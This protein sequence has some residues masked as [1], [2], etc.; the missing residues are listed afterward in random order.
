MNPIYL[1]NAAT[2][3]LSP[4]VIKAMT[5]A[6]QESFGNPSSTHQLGRKAKALVE[7]VRKDLAKQFKVSAGEIFFT[8]GGT[9]ADNTVLR[10]AVSNLNITRFI[11]SKIEHHAVLHTLDALKE[12]YQ[13]QI[14][15]VDLDANGAVDLK[16][17][18]KLLKDKAP[19]TLVSLMHVNNEIGNLLDMQAV[20][21]LC[22]EHQALFHSDT[23]QGVAHFDYDLSQLPIDFMAV[24]A[25]KFYGPKGVGFLFARK[26]SGI[27]GLITGGEQE[28]GLRA[29]TE[30]VHNIV[31]LGTAFKEAYTH[32]DK[33][34]TIVKGLKAYFIQELK[35]HFPTVS[36]NGN[37]GDLEKS[38]YTIL[39]ARFPSASNKMLL[40]TL[41]MKG[42]AV[43][44]GSACQSGAHLGSHVLQEVLDKE[45]LN[46]ASLRFSFSK[47]TTKE[48]LDQAI[49]ILKGSL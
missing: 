9:E 13:I 36:F 25:H 32:L 40:F 31:G 39:N 18:E 1:D 35:H 24:S 20:A 33:D 49:I 30:S 22:Q 19:K 7:Q 4:E 34:S 27:K 23:V 12:K 21:Q 10:S 46:E 26:G 47:Y 44:E 42:L 43:S 17:L 3:P 8:S 45:Q 5:V 2:T 28:R 38:S 41:D 14:D 6:M 29:G 16:H 11:T 48:A 15:F 37:S